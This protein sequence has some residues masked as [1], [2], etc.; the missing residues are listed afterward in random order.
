MTNQLTTLEKGQFTEDQVALIK[1]TLC[2]DATND[3]LQMFIAQCNR[4]GLDPFNRQIYFTKSKDGKVQ[5]GTTVDGFRIIANRHSQYAGQLGPFW[6]GEDGVWTDVWLKKDKPAAAK[7]GVLRHDFKEPVWAIALWEDYAPYF[8]GKLAFMWDKMGAHMLAKCAECLALRKACPH[9]L[10]GI[11]SAEEMK[12]LNEVNIAEVIKPTI[13]P[14]S[15]ETPPQPVKEITSTPA[16]K[17]TI[18]GATIETAKVTE[19]KESTSPKQ[20]STA[21]TESSTSIKRFIPDSVEAGKI[22]VTKAAMEAF[23][24]WADNQGINKEAL[25]TMIIAKY[26]TINHDAFYKEFNHQ[27]MAEM[28]ALIKRE[29]NKSEAEIEGEVVF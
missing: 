18:K 11:Y 12:D 4:T 29:T 8:N 10:S 19:V 5:I 15:L 28:A 20:D 22:L 17:E 26:P 25:W 2:K 1:R 24:V 27:M 3:E 13:K 14:K 6:C 16:K 7:V 23:Q 9:E 21:S